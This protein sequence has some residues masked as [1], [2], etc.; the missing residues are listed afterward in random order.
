M[1]CNGYVVVVICVV[2]VICCNG[3]VV[4][5]ICVVMFMLLLLYVL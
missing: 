3:Y 1:C 4:V 2:M 5:V